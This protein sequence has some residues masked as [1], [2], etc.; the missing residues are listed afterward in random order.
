ME[1][2]G[3]SAASRRG[4]RFTQ[5][6]PTDG[7]AVI[8]HHSPRAVTADLVSIRLHGPGAAYQGRYDTPTLAGWAGAISPWKRE[9]RTVYCCFDND[10]AGYPAE[11]ARSLARMLE[12]TP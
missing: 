3:N 8:C 6:R 9:G 7:A 2:F 11:N 10:E 5:P 1:D 12:A 4:K